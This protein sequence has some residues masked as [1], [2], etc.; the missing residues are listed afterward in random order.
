MKNKIFRKAIFVIFAS[1]IGLL[2]WLLSKNTD[3]FYYAKDATEDCEFL[4]ASRQ[5]V[6]NDIV[7]IRVTK[8][9]RYKYSPPFPLNRAFLREVLKNISD[10]GPSIIGVDYL[11]DMPSGPDDGPLSDFLQS[12]PIPIV[13]GAMPDEDGV[14]TPKFL[15]TMIQ[16]R[17][18]GDARVIADSFGVAKI[19]GGYNLKTTNNS[20]IR[21]LAFQMLKRIGKSIPKSGYIYITE[22]NP[23]MEGAGLT[24][25]KPSEI[26]SLPPTALAGKIVMVGSDED[27]DRWH[28]ARS[29]FLNDPPSPGVYGHISALSQLLSGSGFIEL[30]L[31]Q[32]IVVS[33]SIAIIFSVI[34]VNLTQ[35]LH[36]FL[37]FPIACVVLCVMAASLMR[38]FGIMFPIPQA[39][40][41]IVT[42]LLI[43]MT[44]G[45]KREGSR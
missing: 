5:I 8:E 28:G 22:L 39:M 1:V 24:S 21:P 23:E 16:E 20:Y 32:T 42:S 33:L 13:I 45:S 11:F 36:K 29:E 43:V 15:E 26:D 14:H 3:I 35:R 38:I 9:D 44:M 10:R 4:F 31:S 25:Y 27:G 40:I 7:L 17:G 30:S 12:Q 41:T 6:P 2:P 34:S 37:L 18:L 19:Y